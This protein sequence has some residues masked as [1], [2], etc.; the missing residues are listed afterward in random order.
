[1]AASGLAGLFLW[2]C[3][4]LASSPDNDILDWDVRPS[5]IPPK[6]HLHHVGNA[7]MFSLGGGAKRF[8]QS[9]LDTE[10][11][12]AALGWPLFPLYGYARNVLG[13]GIFASMTFGTRAPHGWC[14]LV[15]RW[16]KCGMSLATTPLR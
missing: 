3:G 9:R 6:H 4:L 14:K 15:C 8:L 1:M 11:S 13:S 12:V 10:T 5:A 2:G 16:L 7:A